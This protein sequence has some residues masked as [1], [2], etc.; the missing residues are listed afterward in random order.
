MSSVIVL[1]AKGRFG[2]AAVTA[3]RAA[4]WRVTALARA[5]PTPSDSHVVADALDPAALSRAC[6]GHDVIVHAIHPPYPE[7]QRLVPIMTDAVIA[8]ARASGATVIIP[9]NVYN[10]GTAMPETLTERTPWVGNTGKGDIRIRM[11]GKFRDSG[12]RT[13]VLRCGDFIDTEKAGNWLDTHIAPKAWQGKISYPGPHDVPH[14]W[15]YLPDAARAVVG[16]AEQRDQFAAFETF[17]FE[18]YTL[19]GT[20]L[21]AAIAD[22][23]GRRVRV[24]GFPWSAV[25]VM[26]LWSPL[27]REVLE[28]RYLWN[29][30][31]RLDGSKLRAALPAFVP[32][33]LGEAMQTAMAIYTHPDGFDAAR[34]QTG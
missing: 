3:F 7:W 12:V 6:M 31:H 1:G 8:A 32:T 24:A 17:G 33:P 27:M 22:V 9:G 2:R 29:R 34:A 16:L 10:Y 14:A 25:R 23:V 11:E 18:G 26:A 5:W 20:E 15:A 30:A 13:I 21:A 19:T 4:G 28:M